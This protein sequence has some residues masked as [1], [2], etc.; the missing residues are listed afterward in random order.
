[1]KK[2][3]FTLLREE[4]ACEDAFSEKTHENVATTLADIIQQEDGGIT[5]GL[6]GSWG[7]GKSTVI[8][9]LAA[10]LPKNH[11]F[12]FDA[13]AHEGDCLRRIFLESLLMSI[14]NAI[15]NK[16]LMGDTVYLDKLHKK[17]DKRQKT[18]TITSNRH[19][20]PMGIILAITIFLA[21]IGLGLVGISRNGDF[22]FNGWLLWVGAILMGLPVLACIVYMVILVLKKKPIFSIRS[23]AFVQCDSTDTVDQEVSEDDERSSIEFENFFSEIMNHVA[24]WNS[25]AK[26]IFAIDN[27]D[28]I[29]SEDSLRLWSTLQTFLQKRN[30]TKERSKWFKKLW[31]I[32]PHDPDGLAK[33]WRGTITSDGIPESAKS[34]LDKCFQVRLEVPVPIMTG[35]ENFTNAQMEKAIPAW[36]AED[37]KR[38]LD[39]LK[40][41]RD[42]LDAIPTPREIKN[43]INQ[44]A[45]L[46]NHAN[47]D[48]STS[49]I[50]YYVICRYVNKNTLSTE[51]IRELLVKTEFP[52]KKHNPYLPEGCANDL[53][54]LVFGVA[55]QL[56]QQL[57]LEPEIKNALENGDDAELHELIKNHEDGFWHVFDSYM[58]CKKQW[59]GK[60]DWHRFLNYAKCIKNSDADFSK[61]SCFMESAKKYVASFKLLKPDDKLAIFPVDDEKLSGLVGLV[62]LLHADGN[63]SRHLEYLFNMVLESCDQNILKDKAFLTDKISSKLD[64][65]VTAFPEKLRVKYEFQ[66]FSF[67]NFK[68]FAQNCT[69]NE[70]L[71][72]ASWIK[73]PQNIVAEIASKIKPNTEIESSLLAAVKYAC[74]AGINNWT[75]VIAACNTHIAYNSGTQ[76]NTSHSSIILDVLLALAEYEGDEIIEPLKNTFKE[77]HLYNFIGHNIEERA[78]KGAVLAA[79]VIPSELHSL[80][81]Q[82][83]GQ[84][85]IG[86]QSICQ[87]WSASNIE[88]AQHILDIIRAWNLSFFI[89]DIGLD[90]KN[91][92][93]VDIVSLVLQNGKDDRLFDYYSAIEALKIYSD[94][95]CANNDEER[96][97]KEQNLLNYLV[98]TENIIDQLI[99]EEYD[100][101]KFSYELDIIVRSEH[102]VDILINKLI[103][104]CKALD[105]AAIMPALNNDHFVNLIQSLQEKNKSFKMGHEFY[106][107]LEQ[108]VTA[109]GE[110][111]G[112]KVREHIYKELSPE[113][114]KSWCCVLT[115][116][117]YNAL[118][119][120]ITEK[121]VR[122]DLKNF[123]NYYK[124]NRQHFVIA[125]IPNNFLNEQTW[126]IINAK[127]AEKLQ[128]FSSLIEEKVQEKQWEIVNDK[129]E[130][131]IE[132]L[133]NWHRA[134]EAVRA[135]LEI[136]AKH[137]NISIAL[138]VEGEA[139]ANL[140]SEKK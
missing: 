130:L 55:P 50:A 72:L 61:L 53:A 87:I 77:R 13:W 122:Y 8:S 89:W 49:S 14:K 24:E 105:M 97:P 126:N 15:Y 129:R 33:I 71:Y 101:I 29:A 135:D 74:N 34:F 121:F 104:Y 110:D 69:A 136:I 52:D 125:D 88:T 108:V 68:I 127:D 76:S 43:Y 124:F 2:Y 86:Y 140:E 70:L 83:I 25:D 137:F 132:P 11:F 19:P 20:T 115:P 109:T 98:T 42:G 44:V 116:H 35:W 36:A 60:E 62:D 119:K 103:E 81:L 41:T 99:R 6:E 94:F 73:P 26:F 106:K 100:I 134:Q 131:I 27:L 38:I 59:N 57:L 114:W 4:V 117:Y 3:P 16:K 47:V 90:A 5:I 139:Q 1:M 111:I 9:I 32:V 67:D 31:I 51:K 56:G 39:V 63:S 66:A 96:L 28:R 30:S 120:V 85:Q 84:S 40:I 93:F 92:L 37:K 112:V 22:T 17:I 46:R 64:L 123:G 75:P 78:D 95:L 138:P 48:I 128:W 18:C 91:K 10:K 107:A 133:R 7:S 23:W 113:E 80:K 79:I 102:I 21:T 65:F 82:H 45:L 58:R 12:V 54:G 118:R